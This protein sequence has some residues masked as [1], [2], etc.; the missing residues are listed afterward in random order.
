[1]KAT[2][3]IETPD[4]AS[5]LRDEA[6][7]G[8]ALS[9]G[10]VPGS[11]G[12]LMGRLRVEEGGATI[13]F[14]DDLQFLVPKL[15]LRV[16]RRLEDGDSVQVRMASWPKSYTLTREGAMVC[17]LDDEQGEMAKLEFTSFSTA[18]HDCATRFCDYIG[19]LAELDPEW[20]PLHELLLKELAN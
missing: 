16:P 1:M 15:C 19:H 20:L 13:D 10:E 9:A 8:A 2:F 17:I 6:G 7:A 12:V 3:L 5:S 4:D 18:L 14:E 11:E